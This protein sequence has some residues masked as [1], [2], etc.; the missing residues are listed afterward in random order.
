MS[1]GAVFRKESCDLAEPE[2]IVRRA[3]QSQGISL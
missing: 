3:K 1:G 2:R